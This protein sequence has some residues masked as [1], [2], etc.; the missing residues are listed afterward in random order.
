MKKVII[1][2]G[3]II[4]LL[5]IGIG[6]YGLVLSGDLPF[7]NNKSNTG[8]N[9][10]N[11]TVTFTMEDLKNSLERIK[12]A[13]SIGVTTSVDSNKESNNITATMNVDLTTKENET[14]ASLKGIELAHAYTVLENGELVD[15]ATVPMFGMNDW[16]KSV[17]K[18]TL[19]FDLSYMNL[20]IENIS[21]FRIEDNVFKALL[22]KEIASQILASSDTESTSS[23]EEDDTVVFGDVQAQIKLSNDKNTIDII[24]DYSNV[25]KE[26]EETFTK[27]IMTESFS[28]IDTTKIVVPDEVRNNA[29]DSSQTETGE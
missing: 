10:N 6:I 1:I 26:N 5:L 27:F 15:Y 8:G 7:L 2:I 22:P 16:S 19:D 11:N 24:L 4:S 17:G 28:N 18:S 21:L 12:N 23:T 14:V 29:V 9:N 20:L 3:T 13:S 25:I